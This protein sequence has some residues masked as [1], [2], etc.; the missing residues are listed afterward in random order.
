MFQVIGGSNIT[1]QSLYNSDIPGHQGLIIFTQNETVADTVKVLLPYSQ[2]S[3][4]LTF[5][6]NYIVTVGGAPFRFDIDPLIVVCIFFISCHAVT[7]LWIEW[8]FGVD[9]VSRARFT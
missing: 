6:G 3:F 2:N 5:N 4:P 8:K 7:N 9:Y 1:I